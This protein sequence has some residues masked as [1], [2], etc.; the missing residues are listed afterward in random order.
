MVLNMTV[1]LLQS[2]VAKAMKGASCNKMIPLTS[3]MAIKWEDGTVTLTTTDGTNYLY[4]QEDKIDAENFYV[5]VPAEQFSKLIAKMTCTTVQMELEDDVLII[6]GNGTYKMELPLDEEG[7]LV[8]YPDPLHDSPL[9]DGE[10]LSSEVV[11]L[12]TIRLI[13]NTA[14][15]S[16]A[17]ND[18][19]MCYTGYYMADSVIATDT[20]KICGIKTPVFEEPALISAETL[21]LL[22]VFSDEDIR[23]HRVV[24]DG[25]IA[26]ISP[27]CCVY[28][29]ELDCIEDFAVEPITGLLEQEFDSSCKVPKA[30]LLQVLDRL[31]L[32]VTPYDKNVITLTFAKDGLNISS[33]KTT[34]CEVIPYVE[35]NNFKAFTCPIDIEMLRSQVKAN[36]A[37]VIYIE[38]GEDNAIKMKEGNVTQIVAVSED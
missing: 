8:K 24:A 13:L 14:K 18:D 27:K 2:M 31:A 1:E 10:I 26:F 32:F 12:S 5:V 11:K 28:G 9:E 33:K 22:N 34:G 25:R 7:R 23:V 38:Y 37:D 30:D 3:L 17:A 4:V 6:R 29:V 20:Y 16:I 35:S 21:D 36:A 15:A 19:V